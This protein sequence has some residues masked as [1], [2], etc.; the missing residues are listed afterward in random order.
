MIELSQKDWSS[1]LEADSE[2][3]IMDVRTQ[4]EVDEGMIPEA[5][6]MDIYNGQKFISSL[7]KLDKSLGYYVYCRSGNR[8][9]QACSIMDQLGFKLT[10]NLVGGFLGWTGPSVTP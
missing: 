3:V 4:E 5:L 2:S 8:S 1:Q 9:A 6:H 7:E 10:F